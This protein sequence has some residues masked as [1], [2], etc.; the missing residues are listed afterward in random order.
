MK[1]L[2]LMMF[3]LISISSKTSNI[4]KNKSQVFESYKIKKMILGEMQK[5]EE[6][7]IRLI[8]VYVRIA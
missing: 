8:K 6:I 1:I 7:Q 5:V 4:L 3:I 2:L